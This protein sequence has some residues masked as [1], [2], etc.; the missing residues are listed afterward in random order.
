MPTLPR[1]LSTALLLGSLAALDANAQTAQ[2]PLN[3]SEK[4]LHVLNR[5]AYGPRPGD[6]DAVR[7]LGVKRYIEQQLNPDSLPLPPELAGKLSSLTTYQLS[8]T[9]LYQQYGP[10]SFPPNT[11]TPEEKNMARQRANKDITPQTHFSRL[12]LAT[13]SPRQLQEVM[14]EFWFNHFN[15]FEGKEWVRYWNGEYE[16]DVLRPNAL[17]NFRQLLGAVAHHPAMLYYLDNWLSSGA[18]TPEAKGRFKGLNENYGR[19]LLELH[20]MGVDSGYTQADVI[21]LARILSG[22]TIDE[23]GMKD[24]QP[25]FSFNP[26]RH[27]AGDK[28]FLGQAIKGSGY[29]EGEQAL[30]ILARHPATAH[31]VAAKLVQYFVSDKPEPALTEKLARRF[32]SS[33]GDIKAVLHTL[34]ESPEF[35]D[36]GNYQ[37]QFKTPYQ[38]VV[39]SLR[40]TATPV[41]NVRPIDGVLNQLGQPLY[42]WLTPEGYKFSEEAWLNPDA[43]LRRINFVN[44][45][46]NGKSP[47]ARSDPPPLVPGS[48]P[49]SPP[50]AAAPNTAVPIDPQQL[51]QTLAPALTPHSL[52]T[53]GAAPANLQ[54]GLILGSPDFM[55]R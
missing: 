50:V 28:V 9:Q 11:A 55:K 35:W 18:G 5:L 23:K 49:G 2:P 1:Y 37:A 26:R 3:D 46:S 39:S 44:G 33:N 29:Q 51:L 12:W 31:F 48:A 10:P 21:S 27:D 34:F 24:G 36:R 19:E 47:I 17:G 25:A 16:K 8:A 42:G 54:V 45:L 43:L 6:V 38:Y 4:A 7:R 52:G 14:T 53:I 30:D 13:E 40:A 20:T 22:W 32:L 15:V 41:L